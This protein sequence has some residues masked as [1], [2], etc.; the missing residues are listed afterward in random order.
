M[1]LVSQSIKEIDLIE[2]ILFQTLLTLVVFFYPVFLIFKRAGLN[3]N[4]SFTIFIPF[5]GYLVCPLVLVFSKWNTSKIVED[6]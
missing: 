2:Q 3:T 6:N 1:N 4:L 5:I